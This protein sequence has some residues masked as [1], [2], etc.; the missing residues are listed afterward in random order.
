[1]Q[2]HPEL[3]LAIVHLTSLLYYL[4]PLLVFAYK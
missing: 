3:I 2:S 4:F 1:M